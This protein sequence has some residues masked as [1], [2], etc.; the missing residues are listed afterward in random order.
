[1]SILKDSSSKIRLKILKNKIGDRYGASSRVGM[2]VLDL[3]P[4]PFL[5]HPPHTRFLPIFYT[6]PTINGADLG[7]VFWVRA[8]CSSLP[9]TVIENYM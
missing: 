8:E 9:T 3:D 6:I 5:T 7:Q 4:N 2:L 1:M